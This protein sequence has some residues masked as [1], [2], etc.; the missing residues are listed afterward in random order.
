MG[1]AELRQNLSKHL[2]RVR[3]GERIVVTDHNRPIATLGPPPGTESALERLVAEGRLTAPTQP[4]GEFS[5]VKLRGA[6]PRAASRALEEVRGE[7]R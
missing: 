6:D 5:P 1:I 3:A 4:R 7:H 2:R